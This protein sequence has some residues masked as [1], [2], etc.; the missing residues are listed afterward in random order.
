MGDVK[1]MRPFRERLLDGYDRSRL[2]Q[3][4]QKVRP[5]RVQKLRS[6]YAT[7]AL[8]ATLAFGGLAV[9]MR[10]IQD[11]ESHAGSAG[12]NRAPGR[13][14]DAGKLIQDAISRDEAQSKSIADQV[15]GGFEAVAGGVRAAAQG[16]GQAARAPLQTIATAPKELKAI[17]EQVKQRFF[18]TEVPFGSIIYS[19]AMKND[20]PPELV[21]AVV[22]TESKF[23]PA[24]RSNRGAIGLM[25]LIPR[26]GRWMGARDLTNPAENISAGARY[27]RYLMD[28]FNGDQQKAVAAYNAGEGSV[29]RFGGIPPFR[30]TRNYVERVQSFQQDLGD[31]MQGQVAEVAGQNEGR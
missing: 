17:T 27:L 14:T 20:L 18:S 16:V 5:R 25:Q 7:L 13:E 15:A 1:T 28:R 2:R 8:G 29:R 31:R 12:E 3:E 11:A 30:E 4:V 22:H 23:L 26:T 19:E 9:P 10:V 21:A 6:R 24:A